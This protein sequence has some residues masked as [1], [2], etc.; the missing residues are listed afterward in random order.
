MAKG[1]CCLAQAN[2]DL[3]KPLRIVVQTKSGTSERC[4]VCE[5][6]QSCSTQTSKP[7]HPV[8]RFRFLAGGECDLTTGKC[9]PTTAGIAQYNTERARAGSGLESEFFIPTISGTNG[10]YTSIRPGGAITRRAPYVLPP[11]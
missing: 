3:G 2:G 8:F 1:L 4:G 11:P 6:V 7:P 9:L 10:H 5:V